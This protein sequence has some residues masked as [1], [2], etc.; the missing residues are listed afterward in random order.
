MGEHKHEKPDRIHLMTPEKPKHPLGWGCE[1]CFHV[2]KDSNPLSKQMIC[3]A[4]PP[5]P[6][7]IMA[8]NGQ[9]I[10]MMSFYPP[11][12]QGEWCGEFNPRD[13]EAQERVEQRAKEVL[14]KQN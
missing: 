14:G 9:L 13:K 4:H 7:A 8:S 11:V 6:Q 1:D 2:V 5:I 3:R 12:N 10:G